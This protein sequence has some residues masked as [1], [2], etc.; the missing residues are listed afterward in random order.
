M[1]ETKISG[2]KAIADY[3]ECSWSTARKHCKT[4]KDI[5]IFYYTIAKKPV[6]IKEPYEKRFGSPRKQ[7]I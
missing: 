4:I 1:A 2:K 6:L 7:S 5:K 3:F